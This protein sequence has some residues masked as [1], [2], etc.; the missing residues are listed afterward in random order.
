MYERIGQG[1]RQEA[2]KSCTRVG[3]LQEWV[4]IYEG[5]CRGLQQ[6]ATKSCVRPITCLEKG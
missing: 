3:C 4:E 5:M 6:E 1:L 2:T